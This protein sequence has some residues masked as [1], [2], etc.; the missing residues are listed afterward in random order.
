MNGTG[1]SRKQFCA[2]RQQYSFNDML[3]YCC[4]VVLVYDSET[5]NKSI[6]NGCGFRNMEFWG[7]KFVVQC[8]YLSMQQYRNK[9]VL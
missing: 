2:D 3:I 8:I 6:S 7:C 1:Q 9:L 5:S 4:A